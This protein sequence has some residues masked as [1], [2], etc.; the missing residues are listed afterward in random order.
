MMTQ[1][2][3]SH[4]ITTIRKTFEA[5]ISFYD[6]LSDEA[7]Q[8]LYDRM[9]ENIAQLEHDAKMSN[10]TK[11]QKLQVLTKTDTFIHNQVPQEE[12]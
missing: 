10:I 1:A 8:E 11:T 7:F 3:R 4:S 9:I 12:S 2:Q 5:I 6:E